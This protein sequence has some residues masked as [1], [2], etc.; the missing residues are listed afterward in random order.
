MTAVITL[1][2]L[3]TLG[4][5][6]SPA[7]A[8]AQAP[9]PPAET[10]ELRRSLTVS[11]YAEAYYSYNFGAPSNGLNAFR[12]FDASHDH[13][14]LNNLGLDVNWSIGPVAG[15]TTLQLGAVAGLAYLPA[16]TLPRA[17]QE[18]LWRVLQEVTLGW[19]PRLLGRAPLTVEGGIFVAPFGV[20]WVQVYRNWTW[21]PTNFFYVAPF[22]MTGG[23]ASWK[24]N[25]RLTARAGVYAGMDRVL[26]DNN[27][28]R[29]VLLQLEY[30][31]GD[32]LFVSAQYM[33][34]VERDRDAPGGPWVRHT[35][36]L[37]TEL[38]ASRRLQLRGH[39]YGGFEPNRTGV[40][41]W[42]SA[43]V[44]ARYE[45]LS[46][47]FLAGRADVVH[48]W[49]PERGASVFA[50]DGANLFGSGTLTVELLPESHL[51]LR[52]EYRHDHANG[53]LYF[54]GAVQR[55]AGVDIPNADSQD[56]VMVGATTWF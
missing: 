23:R 31:T 2:H 21:S 22:Q 47:L 11:G 5:A 39:L 4:L 44:S 48:E 42:F 19:S 29:S 43:A 28:D 50:L 12:F 33:F 56:T 3:A 34:G 52:V 20:E 26:D 40:N 6:L 32:D 24:F 41:G 9:S 30:T 18:I 49:V 54:A 27:S 15:H 53:P 10:S 13:I 38:R 51:S 55:A 36:D 14:A 7:S 1:R 17:Q 8:L 45:L 25:D 46:W 16:P 37:F 35:F